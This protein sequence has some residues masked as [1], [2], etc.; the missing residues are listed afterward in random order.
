LSRCHVHTN[1]IGILWDGVK[2]RIVAKYFTPRLRP[3]M[4][5]L[6]HHH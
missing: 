4:L 2:Y 5:G 1:N 6:E 3:V